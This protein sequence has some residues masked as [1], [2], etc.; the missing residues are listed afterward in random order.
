VEIS[1]N[2]NSDKGVAQANRPV[3]TKL[4]RIMIKVRLKLKKICYYGLTITY[5]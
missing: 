1:H 3:F 5:Y 4:F 2:Q